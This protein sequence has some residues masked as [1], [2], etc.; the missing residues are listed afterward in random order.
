MP[1]AFLARPVTKAMGLAALVFAVAWLARNLRPESLATGIVHPAAG[2]A[3][4]VLLLGG[5]HLW[6]AVAVGG[7]LDGLVAGQPPLV[8]AGSGLG[9]GLAALAGAVLLRRRWDVSA[10]LASV[11]DAI[12]FMLF[13][14]LLSPAVSASVVAL[15][16]LASGTSQSFLPAWWHRWTGDLFGVLLVAP[17]ILTWRA[18]APARS[19]PR[20]RAI[21]LV[22]ES[23]LIGTVASLAFVAGIEQ[24]SVVILGV[25]LL[26]VRQG[27]RGGALGVAIVALAM[28]WSL[29]VKGAL[30]EESLGPAVATMQGFLL[31]VAAVG[32]LVGAAISEREATA[33]RLEEANEY[34]SA[35]LNASPIAVVALDVEG[36]VRTWNKAAEQM[37]GYR[38]DEVIGRPLPYVPE[39]RA[40]EYALLRELHMKGEFLTGLET[41]RLRRDGS[42]VDVRLSLAP[43]REPNGKLA[44]TMGLLEDLTERRH[45]RE[46]GERLAAILEASSELVAI[47]DP[48]GRVVYLNAGGRRMLGLPPEAEVVGRSL[49][50]FYASWAARQVVEEGIPAARRV[51]QWSGET[52]LVDQAG[53]EIP[54]LQ[55]IQAHRDA[56][57]ELQFLSTI[58]RD[59]RAQKAVERALLARNELLERVFDSSPLMISLLQPDGTLEWVNR[60]WE[61][62]LG[63]TLAEAQ[64]RDLVAELFPDPAVRAQVAEFMRC[65]DGTWHDFPTRLRN[66]R[67]TTMAWANVRLS[68]GTMIGLGQDV[69]AQR[70][71]EEQLQQS[72]KM[73]AVGQLA[74]GVAHDFN[75]LLTSII[76]YTEELLG[77][78]EPGSPPHDDAGEIKKAADRAAALTRQLLTF[79]RR[80]LV[81]PVVIDVN[82]TISSIASMLRRLLGGSIELRT[83]LAASLGRIKADPGQIDRVIVNLAVNARDA[84]PHGGT[85]TIR[86]DDVTLEYPHRAVQAGLPAGPYVSVVVSDTGVGMEESVRARVFEPFFT[87]KDKAKGTGLGLATVYAVVQQT[88]GFIDVQSAPGQGAVFS[89][90]FPRA[91]AAA[92]A[93]HPT[94]A[95]GSPGVGAETILVVE[96]ELS[97]RSLAVRA[98]RRMGYHVL[99]AADAETALQLS[100]GHSRPIHLVLTDVMMTG[101]TGPQLVAALRE[102]RGD[103][104]VLYMSGYAAGLVLDA[105]LDGTTEFLPKPFT[106]RRLGAKVREVLDR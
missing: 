43:L 60:P 100:R 105:E 97:V 20:A 13:G 85:L 21:E 31:V 59:N 68:D 69:S 12:G 66:G 35:L 27:S 37:F 79:S 17:P 55:L 36:R 3:L 22:V 16:A 25:A 102:E 82:E 41:V 86:T 7:L 78:L 95:D 18:P 5:A 9:A 71:L 65:A 33:A 83:E 30:P 93:E 1:A 50:G 26:A 96:D 44:G 90:Y 40:Q 14:V 51:G 101:R 81:E 72:Q 23:L 89:L 11:R 49:T 10:R 46:A 62:T 61:R 54:A 94:P 53:E 98:L 15:A 92:P 103:F 70:A 52:A 63:W 57:G 99:E 58:V 39:D 32:L 34:A 29:H 4:A 24:L 91:L 77:A 2:V 48:D 6:P 38:A 47:A 80:Q 8:A 45:A 88:G 56:R 42:P 84:M 87:T 76:G 64:G 73:E 106:A 19:A 75:N 28:V 67:V 104:R 74:G